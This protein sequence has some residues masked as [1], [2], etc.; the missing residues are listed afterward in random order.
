MPKPPVKTGKQAK[1]GMIGV[2][3][4]AAIPP[5][6]IDELRRGVF[7]VVS[8]NLPR[9]R[10]VLAGTRKW[11]PQQVKLF[12]TLM[13]KVMPE[14]S[15]SYSETHATHSLDEMSPEQLRAIIAAETAKLD[16]KLINV[17]PLDP[18]PASPPNKNPSL[19]PSPI[20]SE[21]N[22]ATDDNHTT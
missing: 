16:N 6:K 7:N 20:L 8:A 14:L 22:M 1:R 17:T 4:L 10:E 9:V 12:T 15:E 21:N 18:I 2:N 19:M 13:N 11:D 3:S 5:E